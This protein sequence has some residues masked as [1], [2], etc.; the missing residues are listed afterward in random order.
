MNFNL[1]N[2]SNVSILLVFILSSF[3]TPVSSCNGIELHEL[4]L[5]FN[6]K[7][8]KQTIVYIST[9]GINLKSEK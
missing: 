8:F 6:F 3:M 5:N 4:E 1:K 9:G 7:L 2:N